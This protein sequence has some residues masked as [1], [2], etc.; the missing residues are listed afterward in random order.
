MGILS[1]LGIPTCRSL[2]ALLAATVGLSLT[3]CA[4][5]AD[6]ECDCDGD[7][8]VSVCFDWSDQ[9]TA[10]PEGMSVLFY[11]ISGA[12][13]WRYELHPEGG[14]L[15]VPADEYD[16][17]TYNNDT[18]VILFENQ[19]EF[20]RLLITCREAKISDGLSSD[21]NYKEPPLYAEDLDQPI[22]TPPDAVWSASLEDF[23]TSERSITF[24]PRR[25]TSVYTVKVSSVEHAESAYLTGMSVS[26]LSA[27][28]SLKTLQLI[29][30]NVVMPG[31]LNRDDSA[32]FSGSIRV[33]GH[34]AGSASCRLSLYFFLR[35][36]SK[37][38]FFYDVTDQIENAKD[39]FNVEIH[40]DGII[41]PEIDT[42]GP[43]SD[44][45]LDVGLDDWDI[46]DIELEN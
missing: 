25:M 13:Y 12:P 10:K 5:L 41:L 24:A 6:C 31:T 4:L 37:K 11:P 28:R 21:W 16:V 29:P 18:S 20:D 15:N 34:I 17:V 43:P 7:A 44:S 32:S 27:G 2:P 8:K 45:G 9:P 42:T 30:Y 3:S 1:H 36:G 26:G 22:L 19:N 33:F 39:P 38:A 40:V 14:S 46:I 35:D 23:F